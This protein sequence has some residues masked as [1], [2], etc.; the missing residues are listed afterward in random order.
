MKQ[1]P[2]YLDKKNTYFLVDPQAVCE[3]KKCNYKFFEGDIFFYVDL[4]RK[5]THTSNILCNS[6]LLDI[7]K[8]GLVYQAKFGR[9]AAKKL[10]DFVP[11]ILTPP[12]FKDSKFSPFDIFNIE[13]DK[14][15][16]RAFISRSSPSLEGATIGKDLE[17]LEEEETLRLEKVERKLLK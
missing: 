17:L 5:K 10:K 6:C 4:W 11:V 2:L 13:S 8:I 9:I 14:T 12:E 3:G 15:V 7:E 1:I 16:D